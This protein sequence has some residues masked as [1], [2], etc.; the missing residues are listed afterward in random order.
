MILI[1]PLRCFYL[2]EDFVWM[3]TAARVVH[4]RQG[5]DTRNIRQSDHQKYFVQL[6]EGPASNIHSVRP[7]VSTEHL[8]GPRP[9]THPGKQLST[10]T[11][12]A[13]PAFGHASRAH[14]SAGD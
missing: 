13:S 6:P 10:S 8:L 2:M 4:S 11:D 1:S 12:S 9:H 3:D 7:G 5:E 14:R